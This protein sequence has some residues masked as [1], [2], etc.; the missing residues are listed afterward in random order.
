MMTELK[1]KAR[2]LASVTAAALVAGPAFAAADNADNG[3]N[4]A[5]VPAATLETEGAVDGSITGQDTQAEAN[6]GAAVSGDADGMDTTGM[7]T[8]DYKT[9]TDLDAST[10][11]DAGLGAAD[12]AERLMEMTAGELIGKEVVSAEGEDVGEIDYVIKQGGKLAGVVGVG[13]FLGLGE[14]TVAIP[15]QDF[16][17]MGDAQ[18]KLTQQ[19]EEGLEAMPEVNEA[20]ITPLE[21][22]VKLRE[23]M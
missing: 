3:M 2:I 9:G 16:E 17:M 18:L 8:T 20:S 22:D 19:T 1:A 23:H 21:D 10:S 15:L 13:G 14:H 4:P 11:A 7:D 12:P 6:T 5:D